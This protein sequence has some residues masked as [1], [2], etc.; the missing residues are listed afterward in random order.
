ME[1]NI[2]LELEKLHGRINDV[3]DRVITLEAQQPHIN[4]ALL[5]I[6]SGV[7]VLAG[8]IVKALW[9]LGLLILG[10]L[11]ALLFKALAGGALAHFI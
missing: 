8:R 7:T 5:R 11:V 10:P 2:R 4:A 6:E 1:E 3:K 9:A